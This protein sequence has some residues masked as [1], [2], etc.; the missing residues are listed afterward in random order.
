MHWYEVFLL[1]PQIP[2]SLLPKA[3]DP[4]LFPWFVLLSDN[5]FS[6]YS[7]VQ[8]NIDY[9]D[10]NTKGKNMAVGSTFVIPLLSICIP[11]A[12][13]FVPFH[14]PMFLPPF[15]KSFTRVRLLP[16]RCLMHDPCGKA[17]LSSPVVPG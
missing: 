5:W 12:L 9:F 11:F 1:P 10:I 3:L 17:D 6:L 2:R 13:P 4:N 14:S 15:G 8:V 16:D 7:M